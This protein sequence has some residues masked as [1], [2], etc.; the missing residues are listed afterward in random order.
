[1]GKPKHK[2]WCVWIRL[3]YYRKNLKYRAWTKVA[4]FHINDWVL[5]REEAKRRFM[6][7][8]MDPDFRLLPADRKPR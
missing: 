7:I 5:P 4:T 1:M 8:G 3:T 6:E 2:S